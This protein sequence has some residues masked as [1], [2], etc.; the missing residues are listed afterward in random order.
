MHRSSRIALTIGLL[1]LAAA[2]LL[3]SAPARMHAP[4]LSAGV[5]LRI[6]NTGADALRRRDVEGVMRLFTPTARILGADADRMREILRFSFPQM[7]GPLDISVRN[8]RVQSIGGKGEVSFH[9]DVGEH[10]P[11]MDAVYFPNLAVK[12]TLV[13]TRS[14][15]WLGLTTV[16]EWKVAEITLTPP[17]ELP[18]P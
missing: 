5:A 13:K 6:V 16:D 15:R 9:M 17:I 4:P 11:R 10:T 8:L 7:R 1:S 12:M 2:L 18:Q 3:Y 14:A